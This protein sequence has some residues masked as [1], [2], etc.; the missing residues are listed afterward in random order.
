MIT[1]I[2]LQSSKLS[3]EVIPK[4]SIRNEGTKNEYDKEPYTEP[5]TL[6]MEMYLILF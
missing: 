5:Q 3:A 2:I 6:S 1:V 4:R